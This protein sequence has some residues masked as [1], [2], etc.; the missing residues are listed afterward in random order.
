MLA[1]YAYIVIRDCVPKKSNYKRIRQYEKGKSKIDYLYRH[2]Y[3]DIHSTND[4]INHLVNSD[5]NI[6]L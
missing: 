5:N 4:V 1:E 2:R 3:Q 6:D